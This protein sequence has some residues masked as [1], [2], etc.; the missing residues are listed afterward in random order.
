MARGG[1]IGNAYQRALLAARRR[2]HTLGRAAL[3][4]I[5]RSLRDA[6]KE[7]SG[8]DSP[9]SARRG[10]ILRGQLR[11]LIREL[12]KT[13]ATATAK[14]VSTTVR[15]IVEIHRKVAASLVAKHAPELAD[16][17]AARFHS[18]NVRALAAVGSR[19]QNAATFQTLL[20]RH[21]SETAPDVDRLIQ[22]AVARSV[23]A[24]KLAKDVQKILSGNHPDL[25]DYGMRKTDLAGMRTVEYD[26]MRIARTETNNAMRE[27]NRLALAQSPIVAA[28][29]WQLSGNHDKE[30][31]CDDLAKA[32]NGFG[33][34]FWPLNDWPVAPHPH[35]GCYPGEVYFRP[36]SEWTA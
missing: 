3:R 16:A 27:A 21:M 30:D 17:V 10:E 15:D 2:G 26:A 28:A 35:C 18:I 29:R 32:D 6:L 13:A 23:P 11:G 19:T 5:A 12:E 4:D 9:L 33:P 20:R 7:I 25:S 31:E 24:R 22:S 14:S 1:E 36:P 8:S 34:G